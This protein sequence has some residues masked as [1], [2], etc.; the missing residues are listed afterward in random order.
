[1]NVER[2]IRTAV[3]T[4]DVILGTK[5][6]LAAIIDKKAKLVIVASNCPKELKEDLMHY[7]KLSKVHI[8]EFVGSNVDL[9]AVCG[10]PFVV[11]MLA[12][13]DPGDSEVFELARR[14]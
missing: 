10:K 14:T 6:S 5:R 11:S 9:G 13:V 4:G 3:D 12:V 8:H 7:A 1:M 2:A